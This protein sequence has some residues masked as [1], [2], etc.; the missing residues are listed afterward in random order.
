M[1]NDDIEI[2]PIFDQ[3]SK[4]ADFC[5]VAKDSAQA[6]PSKPGHHQAFA[7][8]AYDKNNMIGYVRGYNPIHIEQPNSWISELYVKTDYQ[9]QGT[10][11]NLLRAAENATAVTT[12]VMRLMASNDLNKKWYI[13][14]HKY[15]TWDGKQTVSKKLDTNFTGAIP[16]FNPLAEREFDSGY[17]AQHHISVSLFTG[18][19]RPI[20]A[21]ADNG[22]IVSTL[23]GEISAIYNMAILC[24][25][26]T[27]PGYEGRGYAKELVKR[28]E[29]FVRHDGRA[30]VIMLTPYT[31]QSMNWF[32]HRGYINTIG[33][34][35][36]EKRL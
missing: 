1:K 9:G 33:N 26:H 15:K 35:Q 11:G 24:N 16:I 3:T 12:G 18:P 29:K 10:G 7:F 17:S 14:R 31:D 27:T 30:K 19:N 23:E 34:A 2:F 8:G 6:L 13:E 5:V 4:Y 21:F 25:L 20:F 32:A 36:M 22:K 28:F